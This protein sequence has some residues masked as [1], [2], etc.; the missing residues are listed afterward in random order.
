MVAVALVSACGAT[1]DGLDQLQQSSSGDVFDKGDAAVVTIYVDTPGPARGRSCTGVLVAPQ[2]VVTS[3]ACAAGDAQLQV[4][5]GSIVNGRIAPSSV[6]PV[7]TTVAAG[8]LL[9][10]RLAYAASLPAL[11][12]NEAP[13]GDGSTGAPVRLVGFGAGVH[14][15]TRRTLGAILER[16]DAAWLH[17]ATSPQQV[18]FGNPG[19]AALQRIDGEERLI[20]L[21]TSTSAECADGAD[22]ARLDA[23]ADF[24]RSQL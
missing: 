24:I 5:K 14:A 3:A 17:V 1:P 22:Y 9:L 2:L 8:E 6:V 12:L 10:L 13:L 4:I 7:A 18:C 15:G 23:H 19:A 20:G 21:A 11:A 16:Y